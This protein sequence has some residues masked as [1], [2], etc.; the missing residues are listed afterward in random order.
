MR[1]IYV[2]GDSY[3]TFSE[4]KSWG[5]LI[6]QK[7]NCGLIDKAKP[8]QSN[9]AIFTQTLFDHYD[10]KDRLVIIGWSFPSRRVYWN[11]KDF[12]RSV[13]NTYENIPDLGRPMGFY[14]TLNDQVSNPLAK[15]LYK[16]HLMLN[17]TNEPDYIDTINYMIALDG[18]LA[19]RNIKHLFV[20]A[21]Q[22]NGYYN[23]DFPPLSTLLE[24][25]YRMDC[26][27][28]PENYGYIDDAHQ[29]GFASTI[30]GHLFQ[31][32]HEYVADKLLEFIKEKSL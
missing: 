9:Y 29:Q 19:S 22:W 17:P 1:E 11:H 21:R 31:D 7:L 32:G 23:R 24:F 10:S 18:F 15:E 14:E 6:A 28:N 16:M 30:T 20:S 13:G 4:G 2:C 27:I 8:G 5:H 25:L 3:A 12:Y 26:C